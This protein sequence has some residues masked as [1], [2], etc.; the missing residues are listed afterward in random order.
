MIAPRHH[1]ARRPHPATLRPAA[2]PR[3]RETGFTLIEMLT[4]VAVLIIVLGLM[5]SLA[6]YVRNS[7]ATQL[8][9]GLLVDLDTA[10]SSYCTRYH[11]RAAP[12]VALAP[13]D[14]PLPDEEALLLSAEANNVDYVRL[15]KQAG[16]LGGEEF[17]KLPISVFDSATFRDAWG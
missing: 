7:S 11:L 15:L 1:D 2:Q 8:T 10:M 5:V 6:R 16:A 14:Q 12:V 3:R 13:A 4:T 9:R 17:A